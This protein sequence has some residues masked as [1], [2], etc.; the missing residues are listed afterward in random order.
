MKR[1][2]SQEGQT[3]IHESYD[4]LLLNWNVAHE[5]QQIMTSYGNTHVIIAVKR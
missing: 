4:Q 1:Y 5:Q 2:K 3:L